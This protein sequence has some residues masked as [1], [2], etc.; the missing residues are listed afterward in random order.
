MFHNVT[1]PHQSV[2]LAQMGVDIPVLK[3]SH[4]NS[5]DVRD[6]DITSLFTGRISCTRQV[7]NGL[8]LH[9]Y[10]SKEVHDELRGTQRDRL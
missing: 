4:E 9:F 10:E 1:F 5:T 3:S 6:L 2:A 7:R 8:T